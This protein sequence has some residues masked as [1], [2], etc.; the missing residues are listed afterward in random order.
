[1]YSIEAKFRVGGREVSVER[2]TDAPLHSPRPRWPK[3]QPIERRRFQL[4]LGHAPPLAGRQQV[5]G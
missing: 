5:S 4:N 2:F 3:V 1:M